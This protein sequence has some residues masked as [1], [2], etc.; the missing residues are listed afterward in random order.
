MF[1]DRSLALA[2]TRRIAA[3]PLATPDDDLQEGLAE[4]LNVVLG[5]AVALLEADGLHLSIAPPSL[6]AP[7]LEGTT[8]GITTTEGNGGFSLNPDPRM[9]TQDEELD[10]L[11]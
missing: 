4:F 5:N 10:G 7:S 9:P 11:L 8:L 3:N 1:A 2:I 6:V